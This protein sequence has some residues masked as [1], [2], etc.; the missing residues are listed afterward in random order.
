[1]KQRKY[2]FLEGGNPTLSCSEVYFTTIIFYYVEQCSDVRW[3]K[4][5]TKLYRTRT[6]VFEKTSYSLPIWLVII[7]LFVP[8]GKRSNSHSQMF[9]KIDAY[10][11]LAI[12]TGKH[13]CW[14]FFLKKI[15]KKRLQH[16]CFSVNIA[17]CLST[18]FYTE[19]LF[20]ILFRNF[21]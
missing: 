7:M 4:K 13:L 1:M 2:F 21:M 3:R 19:H 18:A 17:K 8:V 14:S 10:K 20:I 12:F 11:N 16:R 5:K 9:Y 6:F 15:V